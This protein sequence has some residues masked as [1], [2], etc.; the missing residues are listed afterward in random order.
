METP[1]ELMKN[2]KTRGDFR[3]VIG[4]G[5]QQ[6]DDTAKEVSKIWKLW[7]ALAEAYG[8]AFVNQ[9]GEEPSL[10]WLNGLSGYTEEELKRGFDAVLDR[11]SD[12]APNLGTVRRLISETQTKAYH[13]PYDPNKAVEDKGDGY[14][15]PGPKDERTTDQIRE[16]LKSMFKGEGK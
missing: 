10:T 8:N 2:V 12:F 7:A 6:S 5:K 14:R 1:K 11:D 16:D 9:F 3:R 13:R 4:S 15:L